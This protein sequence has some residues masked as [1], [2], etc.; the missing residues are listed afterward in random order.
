MGLH[1]KWDYKYLHL[2]KG[3]NCRQFAELLEVPMGDNPQNMGHEQPAKLEGPRKNA[4]ILPNC[5]TML[6][7]YCYKK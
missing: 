2:V 1:H 3:H 4:A 5:D 7:R 6:G